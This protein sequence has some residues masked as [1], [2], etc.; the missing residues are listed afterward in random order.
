MR[1]LRQETTKLYLIYLVFSSLISIILLAFDFGNTKFYQVLFPNTYLLV[2]FFLFTII[3]FVKHPAIRRNRDLYIVFVAGLFLSSVVAYL[4][5]DTYYGFE[6]Y[7]IDNEFMQAMITKYANYWTLTDFAYK[8]L[9]AFYPPLYFYVVGKISW[10]LGI[11]P[12]KMERYL[13]ILIPFL[14]TPLIY[15]AWRK[16][17]KSTAAMLIAVITP[18]AF[19][20]SMFFKT[21]EYL[22][23]VFLLP[24]WFTFVDRLED[25]PFPKEPKEYR[26]F[27]LL[28]SFLGALLFLTFYY[29]FFLLI[30]YT[31]IRITWKLIETRS[32]MQ[33]W[34]QFRHWFFVAGTMFVMV[35]IYLG[36]LVLSILKYGFKPYQNRYFTKEMLNIFAPNLD[37]IME[38]PYHVIYLIGF[39]A[40]ILLSRHH[41]LVQKLVLLVIA[42]YIW[43]FFGEITVALKKPI[44]HFKMEWMLQFLLVISFGFGIAYWVK[45]LLP[46][47]EKIIYAILAFAFV[48]LGQDTLTV[49]ENA[50][51]YG[52]KK[53][54]KE[55]RAVEKVDYHDK[56]FLTSRRDLYKI[57]PVFYFVVPEPTFTHHASQRDDRVQFLRELIRQEDPKFVAWMLTY[58]KFDKVDYIWME[59]DFS[60]YLVQDHFLK[61]P[62]VQFEEFK[63]HYSIFQS[64]YFR[65]I[66]KG[67]KLYAIR[68][69]KLDD[70]KSFTGEQKLMVKKY[71]DPQ[72]LAKLH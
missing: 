43:Q 12:Y 50:F 68:N 31:A 8:D 2:A 59:Q 1:I 26:K 24:W 36:P 3:Y 44:L 23:L 41:R 7:A 18:M 71:S 49:H 72:I 62:N 42:C 19:M 28:G 52:F 15:F 67:A 34:Q 5:Q 29:W 14:V 39:I 46:Y 64:K 35:L 17:V 55:L 47:K 9:P 13:N 32:L 66:E 40:V 10:L 11:E 20:Y 16:I 38:N 33:V 30:I 48:V 27:V 25:K 63:F 4:Y 21:Y 65:Q 45:K 69:V 6:F 61:L 60:I 51:K 57:Y 58:N 56:V 54:P 37:H 22:S 53:I 70:Y